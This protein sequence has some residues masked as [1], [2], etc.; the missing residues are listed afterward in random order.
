MSEKKEPA[1][2]ALRE[3]FEAVRWTRGS[4]G[5]LR[6]CAGCGHIKTTPEKHAPGCP[7]G[8][9]IGGNK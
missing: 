2:D 1:P 4:S 9:V 6:F 3:A 5:H 7:V 8:K